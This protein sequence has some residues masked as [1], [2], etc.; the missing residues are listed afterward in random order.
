[1]M[2]GRWDGI[3]TASGP[4]KFSESGLPVVHVS[5]GRRQQ[6]AAAPREKPTLTV[7]VVVF[8][9]DVIVLGSCVSV[10][11]TV[12]GT[13]GSVAVLYTVCVEAAAAVSVSVCVRVKTDVT[14]AIRVAVPTVFVK[15]SGCL[16]TEAP[17]S[18]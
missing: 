4:R 17:A 12:E 5:C 6:A 10:T 3:P 18:G 7:T 13:A 9:A 16:H 11:T 14:T 1:M 8:G 15:T 2:F